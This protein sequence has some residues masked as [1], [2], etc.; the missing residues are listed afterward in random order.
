MSYGNTQLN[1][2]HGKHDYRHWD[3]SDSYPQQYQ[4]SE[5][6]EVV[7]MPHERH[8][9]VTDYL[10]P[11]VYDHENHNNIN[12]YGEQ[13]VDHV[14]DHAPERVR[15][16]EYYEYAPQQPLII[17]PNHYQQDDHLRTV[18]HQE[19]VDKEAEDFI[20]AEHRMFGLNK[21]KTMITNGA[22]GRTY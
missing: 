5:S 8:V 14:V 11:K 2:H 18:R 3:T 16:T 19:N 21:L 22:R 10:Y 1:H 20:R 9:G 12:E 13:R 7:S 6:T 4:V 15:V 17:K